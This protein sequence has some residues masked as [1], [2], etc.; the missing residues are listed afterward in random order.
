MV[1]DIFKKFNEYLNTDNK[2]LKVKKYVSFL[3]CIKENNFKQVKLNN[4]FKFAR[5]VNRSKKVQ[6]LDF[7][8]E[9]IK[10][11]ELTRTEI[12]KAFIC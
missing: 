11:V 12:K 10:T 9:T 7:T 6:V 4:S 2:I 1:N 5:V 8:K 3:D